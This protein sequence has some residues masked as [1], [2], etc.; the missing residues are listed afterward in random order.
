MRKVLLIAILPLFML[1]TGC[2]TSH[3]GNCGCPKFG[4]HKVKQVDMNQASVSSQQD[5][6]IQ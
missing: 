6:Q 1:A 2:K 5:N 4:E 3:G